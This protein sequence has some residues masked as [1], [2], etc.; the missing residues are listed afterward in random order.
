M[1]IETMSLDDLQQLA[2]APNSADAVQ[3]LGRFIA[4]SRSYGIPR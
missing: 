2:H 3:R 4:R 1:D